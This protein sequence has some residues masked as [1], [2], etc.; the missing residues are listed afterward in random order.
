MGNWYSNIIHVDGEMSLLRA[1]LARHCT[2]VEGG[3]L[4][5]CVSDPTY[6]MQSRTLD[7]SVTDQIVLTFDTL[8]IAPLDWFALMVSEHPKL[9]F[10]L[11][12]AELCMGLFGDVV[13]CNGVIVSADHRDL[14]SLSVDDHL[15]LGTD[16]ED[17]Q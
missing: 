5:L 7:V 9:T 2:S 17:N 1:W 14:A 12:Y 11:Y 6:E 8:W 4:D 13:A 3:E 15:W 10:G 16:G